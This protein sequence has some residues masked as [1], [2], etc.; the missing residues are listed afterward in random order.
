MK[1]KP[2]KKRKFRGRDWHGWAFKPKLFKGFYPNCN[3]F[4]ARKPPKRLG[5]GDGEWV[6]VKF[7][8]VD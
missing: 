6:R 1:A 4:M 7:V 3:W 2:K 8:P 5:T